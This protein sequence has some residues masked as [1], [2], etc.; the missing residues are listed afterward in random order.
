[1]TTDNG[2][3]LIKDLGFVTATELSSLSKNESILA[4]LNVRSLGNKKTKIGN[5]IRECKNIS[6][7]A[8]QETWSRSITLP[9]Y[10]LISQSR[11]TGRGGG[12]AILHHQHIKLEKVESGIFPHIEFMVVK[13]NNFQLIN[14]YRPP[15][16]AFSDF[17]GTLKEILESA[18]NRKLKSTFLMGDFN[19]NLKEETR[20]ASVI[21]NIALDY[22]LLLTTYHETRL[23]NKN[24]SLIDAIFSNQCLNLTAGVLTCDISDHFAPFIIMKLGPVKKRKKLLKSKRYFNSEK[25]QLIS[26]HMNAVPWEEKLC[27]VDINESYK[28]FSNIFTNELNTICPEKERNTNKK[29]GPINPFMTKGL[30]VS[31]LHKQNL[32]KQNAKCK[33][34]ESKFLLKTYDDVF[35]KVMKESKKITYNDMYESNRLNPRL[36]WQLVNEDLDRK[37]A[38]DDLPEKFKKANGDYTSSDFE[39]ANLLNEHFCNVGH[40]IN[41]QFP[42]TEEFRKYIKAHEGP[43]FEFEPID[44]FAVRKTLLSMENKQSTGLDGMSNKLL[45]IFDSCIA[46]PISILINKSFETGIFPN[47]LKAAKVIALYKTGAQNDPGNY[48]PISL[49]NTISKIF[50]KIA[51]AQLEIH[52]TSI[53]TSR[54]FGFR[55]KTSTID[56]I[57]NYLGDVIKNSPSLYHLM[58]AMDLRKAFDSLPFDILLEKLK[59]YGLG[60]KSLEWMKSY[61]IGRTQVV[62]VRDATSISLETRCGIPQGSV[63]GPFIFIIYINDVINCSSFAKYLFADDT[64][65][66]LH[67][68]DLKELENRAN[69]E[70]MKVSKW[71]ADNQLSVHP[72][73]TYFMLLH[74]KRKTP[75]MHLILNG[76]RIAQCGNKYEVK[77]IKFLGIFLDENL[78]WNEHINHL[79][80]KLR[81]QI[82]LLSQ[83]KKSYPL[84]L[85]LLLYNSLVRSVINYGISLWGYSKAANE[86]RKLLKWAI[87]STTGARFN[88]H[89]APLF[90][91]YNLPDFDTIRDC[92]ALVT[93]RE[94]ITGNLPEE[95]YI[96]NTFQHFRQKNRKYNQFILPM[97][98]H[99]F[100]RYPHYI[101]PKL[102][103]EYNFTDKQLGK[104]KKSFKNNL[105]NFLISK[106][107]VTCRKA[108]CY[109]CR[110]N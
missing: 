109:V 95:Y 78:N 51:I 82:Y 65:L 16:G 91:K 9:N 36:L 56:C 60:T 47:D 41:K 88:S 102:W 83:V 87:R 7:L 30:H 24:S 35:K 45:K 89:T 100:N 26:D 54:Q 10:K 70:L 11:P 67:G 18:K 106:Y 5:L 8:I 81:S 72:K 43:S 29:D 2:E 59:I 33:S 90:A 48:R 20:H 14:C 15:S 74:P 94:Y 84:K 63:I 37:R 101:Y 22:N 108:K 69:S 23:G 53:F 38:Q 64:N 75:N 58:I 79:K 50:E 92:C 28:I 52:F 110:R 34:K 19:I 68:S 103:N 66:S 4:S 12:V 39:I 21:K 73:K 17:F 46:K 55:K 3:A 42:R 57:T 85:R 104:T 86:I 99:P 96:S 105:Q 49:L 1:M 93:M 98:K 71:F 80:S 61:L 40:N 44:E 32:I 6:I 31:W 77:S 97:P 107:D 62:K 76:V 13:G 25:I 27:P